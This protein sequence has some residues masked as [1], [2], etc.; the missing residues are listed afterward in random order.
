MLIRAIP[1]G[2]EHWIERRQIARSQGTH[3]STIV[4]AV[5]KELL[6]KKY[7]TYGNETGEDRQAV[8]EVGY[9][10]EDLLGA[11]LPAPVMTEQGETLLTSQTEIMLDGIYG[12]PDR[13]VLSRDGQ[14]IVEE[15]KATWKWFVPDLEHVKFLYW[16]LQVKTYCA[17]LDARIARIRALFINEISHSD[18]FVVPY[19]WEL[20]FD[21]DELREH[22]DSMLSFARRLERTRG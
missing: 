16:I 14:L 17:M 3:V 22:W 13:L 4:L 21:G 1:S 10:W 5:L 15:T 9:M 2:V 8:F 7:G 20:T 18:N 6:P 12:T 19:C 11:A